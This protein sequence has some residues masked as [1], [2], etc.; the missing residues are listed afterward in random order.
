M[1]SDIMSDDGRE[2]TVDEAKPLRENDVKPP[3]TETEDGPKGPPDISGLYSLKLDNVDYSIR[4]EDLKTMFGVHG[5]I[6][7]I[8]MPRNH[9]TKQPRGFAFVR[10]KDRQAAEDAI[11]EFDQ[12]EIRGRAV[13]CRFAEK[14]RPDN[15]RDLYKDKGGGRGGGG[16]G[17]GY[18]GGGGSYG[19]SYSD[20]RPWG[21]DGR[22]YHDDRFDNRTRAPGPDRG[23]YRDVYDRRAPA[24]GPYDRAPPRD[25]YGGRGRRDDYYDRGYDRGYDDRYPP[26]NHYDNRGSYDDRGY[27]RYDDRSRGYDRR[28][29]RPRSR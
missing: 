18:R 13:A 19:G 23:G 6:G 1:I 9:Q 28:D 4:E 29:E 26:R 8:Y 5:E 12:K 3:T 2:A 21:G 14:P 10:F 15:P 11:K 25:D 17:G 16:R 22:S 24:P 7:D 27:D 20:R